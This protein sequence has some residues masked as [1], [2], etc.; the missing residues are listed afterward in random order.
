[1]IGYAITPANA[2]LRDHQIRDVPGFGREA[3]E[4]MPG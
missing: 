3:G 4:P 1:M 2:R